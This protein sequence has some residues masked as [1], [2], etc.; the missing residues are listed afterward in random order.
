ME[1]PFW[2]HEEELEIVNDV[3]LSVD[4]II[5]HAETLFSGA[6]FLCFVHGNV[7]QTTVNDS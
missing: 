6:S 2:K 5:D 7:N 3:A 4:D 1:R